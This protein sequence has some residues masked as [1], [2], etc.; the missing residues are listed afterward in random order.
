MKVE[1]IRIKNFKSLKE[2]ELTEVP[3]FC[4]FLGRNG[5]GKT[6]LFRTFSF[7]KQ[8]LATDVRRALNREGGRNGFKEVITRG[9]N[10]E[11]DSIGFEI[12]FRMEIAGKSRLVTYILKIGIDKK[13]QPL[14]L[15]EVLRYKRASYGSPYHFLD[16]TQGEGYAITNEDDFDKPDEELDREYQKLASKETLA[17]KGLG[18]FERFKAAKAFKD[19]IEQWHISDFHIGQARGDKDDNGSI[20]LSASGENLPSVARHLFDNYPKRFEQI[21]QKMRNRVP[22][23]DNIEVKVT[24]DGRLIMRYKDGAFSEPFID[25]NVSDGTIKMFAYL[26]LLHDPLPYPILCVEEPENQLY[27]ELMYLLAEE[28]VEYTAHGGQVFVSTHSPQFLN[29]VNLPSLYVIEKKEGISKIYRAQDDPLIS[30]QIQTGWK[31]GTL[32]EQGDMNGLGMRVDS[33]HS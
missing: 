1:T 10:P 18:Q 30:G 28:F 20:H 14:I 23:V 2:V 7:I 8:C 3:E 22:G 31:L 6:T 9:C 33:A 29:A 5:V 21:K 26:V 25:K 12:Q 15:R 24:D 19:L 17:I 11:K 32:W 27:P 16:F 13:K 4:V